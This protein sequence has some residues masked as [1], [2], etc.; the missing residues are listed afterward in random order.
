MPHVVGGGGSV[1]QECYVTKRG[2][3]LECEKLLHGGWGGVKMAFF[4]VTHFLNDPKLTG[5]QCRKTD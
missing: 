4:S 2:Y 3:Q 5:Q 1:L